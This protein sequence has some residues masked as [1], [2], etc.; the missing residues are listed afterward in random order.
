[1][2][3]CRRVLTKSGWII[4]GR[5]RVNPWGPSALAGTF[6]YDR[7]RV[8]AIRIEATANHEFQGFLL[9]DGARTRGK[10]ASGQAFELS[11]RC[12]RVDVSTRVFF[13]L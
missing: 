3:L 11:M 4:G 7:V 5:P 6:P 1:M 2:K 9:D 12:R 10:G 13:L 8:E